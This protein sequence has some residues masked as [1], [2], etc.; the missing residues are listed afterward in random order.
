MAYAHGKIYVAKCMMSLSKVSWYYTIII[1][2]CTN[3]NSCS[4]TGKTWGN[5]WAVQC[6]QNAA[7]SRLFTGTL[8]THAL[9]M[10]HGF[11]DRSQKMYKHHKQNYLDIP[12]TFWERQW[13]PRVFKIMLGF[14]IHIW[15][16][17]GAVLNWSPDSICMY[18]PCRVYIGQ[19]ESILFSDLI[20]F[21]FPWLLYGMSQKGLKY[22]EHLQLPLS[23]PGGQGG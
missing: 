3:I 21:D 16:F 17:G 19:A 20:W 6:A 5:R 9:C 11:K 8:S 14:E 2:E 15:V 1:K 4:H 18:N 22:F 13:E 23:T 12:K 10:V 7:K